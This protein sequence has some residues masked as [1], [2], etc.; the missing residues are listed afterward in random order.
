MINLNGYYLNSKYND[1]IALIRELMN[2]SVIA[3][4]KSEAKT[5]LRLMR[6]LGATHLM[7]D[8]PM[9]EYLEMNIPCH[10]L[11]DHLYQI[12]LHND[13]LVVVV[14][15]VEQFRFALIVRPVALVT[16][17]VCKKSLRAKFRDL[18]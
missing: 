9:S 16:D 2:T 13:E 12:Q 10:G 18:F 14:T 15:P 7:Y 6:Y 1:I 5:I 3:R 4:T 11:K 17:I 8:N